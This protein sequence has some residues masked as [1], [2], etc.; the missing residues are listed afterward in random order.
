VVLIQPGEGQQGVDQLVGQ[1]PVQVGVE[2]DILVGQTMPQRMLAVANQGSRRCRQPT[3]K[4]GNFVVVGAPE[5]VEQVGVAAAAEALGVERTPDEAPRRAR[6]RLQ[7]AAQGR[8]QLREMRRVSV[9]AACARKAGQM[10][11]RIG[12]DD[13]GAAA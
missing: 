10:V 6:L 13:W 4:L 8:R 11:E 5:P 9:P 12:D 1:V 2:Q 3:L 7:H